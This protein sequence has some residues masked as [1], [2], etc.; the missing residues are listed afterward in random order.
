MRTFRTLNCTRFVHPLHS[1]P[2]SAHIDFHNCRVPKARGIFL[3]TSLRAFSATDCGK[4]LVEYLL[5]MFPTPCITRSIGMCIV[6]S[7]ILYFHLI[8]LYF[9][10]INQISFGISNLLSNNTTMYKSAPAKQISYSSIAKKEPLQPV[11]TQNNIP[12]PPLPRASSINKVDPK[13]AVSCKAT[14]TAIS[15][16]YRF[17]ARNPEPDPRYPAD[18]QLMVGPIPGQKNYLKLS[19]DVNWK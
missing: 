2:V 12:R 7:L 6:K 11:K 17:K 3:A 4:T 19:V 16:G 13:K 10:P 18:Q 8:Y 5:R 14:E 15:A 9:S 1:A